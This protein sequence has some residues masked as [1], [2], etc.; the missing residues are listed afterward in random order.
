MPQL[1]KIQIQ[2]RAK[3][4]RSRMRG[5]PTPPGTRPMEYRQSGKPIFKPMPRPGELGP[6]FLEALNLTLF[7]RLGW[8]RRPKTEEQKETGK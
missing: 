4:K 2:E 8:R 1:T 7:R 6:G 5:L 3:R